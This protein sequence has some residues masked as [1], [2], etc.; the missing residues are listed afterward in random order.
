MILNFSYFNLVLVLSKRKGDHGYHI[1][2]FLYFIY[3]KMQ[4]EIIENKIKKN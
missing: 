1:K 4:S 2:I 3:A